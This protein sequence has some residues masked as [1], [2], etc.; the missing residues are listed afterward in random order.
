MKELHLHELD[1]SN[2]PKVTNAS[3]THLPSTLKYLNI[4]NCRQ[5]I[6]GNFDFPEHLR[7][8]VASQTMIGSC[9]CC[10]SSSSSSSSS[11]SE[12]LFENYCHAYVGNSVLGELP[13]TVQC[14]DISFCYSITEQG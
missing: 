12:G 14:V 5:I 7:S 9:C 10:S 13:I 2:C 8:F 1:V 4:T 11:T 3:M 6:N